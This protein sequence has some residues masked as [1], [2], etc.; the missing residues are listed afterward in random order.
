MACASCGRGG[1]PIQDL[2]S[3]KLGRCGRCMRIAF[4]GTAIS[5]V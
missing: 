5:W 2:V 3:G 4:A 1:L